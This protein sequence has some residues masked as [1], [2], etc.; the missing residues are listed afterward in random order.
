[1]HGSKMKCCYLNEYKNRLSETDMFVKSI[2]YLNYN[3]AEVTCCSNH[4]TVFMLSCLIDERQGM[5]VSSCPSGSYENY[6]SYTCTYCHVE[7]CTV[8][9]NNHCEEC[10]SGYKFSYGLEKVNYLVLFIFFLLNSGKI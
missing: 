7:H 2:N 9:P 3:E 8:C 4:M 5:C 6:E 1:M 10:E